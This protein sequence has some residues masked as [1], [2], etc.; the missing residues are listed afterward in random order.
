MLLEA[1]AEKVSQLQS[2][3]RLVEAQNRSLTD[4]GPMERITKKM[5]RDSLWNVTDYTQLLS[6]ISDSQHIVDTNRYLH[7]IKEGNDAVRKKELPALAVKD[8]AEENRKR[9]R[10]FDRD[11]Y[12]TCVSEGLRAV[13]YRFLLSPVRVGIILED[14]VSM[15]GFDF[16][17]A[18]PGE[19]GDSKGPQQWE[20]P[21][22]PSVSP[23][24]FASDLI[25]SGELVLMSSASGGEADAAEAGD[26][27]RG[28]RYVA[29]T[30]LAHEPRVRRTLRHIFA[31]NALV[32][33]RPT[34]KGM[35]NIDAFHD[36]YGLHLIRGK[37]VR[38]HFPLSDEEGAMRRSGMSEAERNE[39]DRV[40]SE[41]ERQSCTQY[42]H[43]LKAEKTGYLAIHIHLPLLE[44][45]DDW[46]RMDKEQL[47]DRNNQDVSSL[48]NELEKVYLPMESDDQ[49]NDERRRVLQLALTSFLLPQYESELRRALRDAAIKACVVEAADNL[50]SIAMVGPYRPAA[51]QHTQNRFLYPTGDLPIVGV[52]CSSDS[53]DATY[54]VSVTERGE[55]SDFLAIPTGVRIDSD[56]MR[57]KVVMFLIQARPAAVVVGTSGGFESRRLQRKLVDLV[58]ESVQRWNRRDIQGEDE[59]DEAFEARQAA[60][61]QMQ[62][63]SH[64]DDEDEEDWTCNV[65]LID[66]SVCQLFGRSVRAKK[67]FPDYGVNL[68][69]AISAARFAKDPLGEI[70]YT[71]S[72]ASDAGVFGT[73]MLYMN[74]HP[75]QQLLPKTLLLRH[76]ERVLCDVVAEVGVDFNAS[77]SFDHLSGLLMFVPGLGPRKA[78]NLKQTVSQMGGSIGRRRDLLEKRFLG[79][80]V[81]NNAVAFLRIREIDQLIDHLLHPLDETRLHPDVYLRN[82]W[83]VKIAFD[84]LEREDPKSKEAAAMKALRDVMDNSHEEVE[85]LFKATQEEWE[86][87]FG[88]QMFNIKGWDPRVNVPQDRWRDKVDELDLDTFANMIKQNGQGRWHSHLEMIK[89]EFRLPFA[90]PRNPMETL[91][92][93]KLFHLITGETDQ[94]LRPGKEITGKVVMNGEFGS[95]IKLEG[96]IPAF[97]PLRNLSDEHVESAEDVVSVGQVI[98]AVVTE[99]KKDHMTVDLSLRLEDFRKTPSSWERPQ[100]LPRVDDSF[101]QAASSRIEEENAKKREAHIEALLQSIG[102]AGDASGENKAKRGRVVRRACTHPAFRNAKQ[103]EVDRELREAGA[104][105]VGEAL[106]R[107]SAKSSDS[108]AIHW[109][110]KEGSIKVIEVMEEDKDADASIG[111]ILKVKVSFSGSFCTLLR[112]SALLTFLSGHQD[113]SYGS[114]DE[115][116]G[117]YIAPMNDNV[118]ELVNHRKFVDLP[119]DEVD[120]RLK[121]QKK[122]T[123]AAIPYALC[124]MEMHP[125]YASLRFLSTSTPRSHPIGISPKGFSWGSSCFPSIEELINQFKKNPRGISKPRERPAVRKEPPAGRPPPRTRWDPK[126][127]TSLPPRPPPPRP[128]PPQPTDWARPPPHPPVPPVATVLPPA[129]SWGTPSAPTAALAGDNWPQAAPPARPPPPPAGPPANMAQAPSY[130]PPP[131]YGAPQIIQPPPV[132][133]AFGS[134]PT[135]AF[136]GGQGRGRGRGRTLPAW[137][138]KS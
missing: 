41:R 1:K 7:L 133:G 23:A 66:D 32:T 119:E 52:C 135:P 47:F 26:P 27:L 94:S 3:V 137:M 50:R 96:D 127:A 68:K 65:E 43:L 115:L 73:E 62:P 116:L 91:P 30:E 78:A 95:R 5:C 121:E 37:P 40:M 60:F 77:C 42:L 90:D 14:I 108:L 2:Q 74:I 79:P 64:Y 48:L 114:I 113:E 85:R 75:M 28:C 61:R 72:V 126:P 76:Y 57:E 88:G 19:D 53:K 21:V 44:V 109:V 84:A 10:R 82:N 107:P 56:K 31:R 13:C 87:S 104:S 129:A 11:F 81:Y 83:A 16:S 120:E 128:P 101:D 89:W 45:R 25:G 132:A 22:V 111:N 70:T 67:E 58:N 49:F 51:I 134:Q 24:E 6:T 8:I 136:D 99:V 15:G 33:T 80:I 59:D 38:D 17:K 34:K 130:A 54:L 69:C 18:M 86:Q 122:A 98:T 35:D 106:I 124:W 63:S 102:K 36:C 71:W 93:D 100:S 20:A 46:Y 92:G 9:S 125:G 105:M 29:A 131:P 12:R 39:L 138:S 55:A 110:V 123:P 112:V 118:E 4:P 103:N 117:R 97:V